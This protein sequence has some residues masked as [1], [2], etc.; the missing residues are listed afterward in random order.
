MA[1]KQFKGFT[2]VELLVVI[3]IIAI[4]AAVIVATTSSATVQARDAQRVSTI[5]EVQSALELYYNT[6]S[7]Y[8]CT[9]SNAAQNWNTEITK[10]VNAGYISAV[11]T[12][13]VGGGYTYFTSTCTGSKTQG[14]VLRADLEQST[15][16]AGTSDY[17]YGYGYGDTATMTTSYKNGC[18]GTSSNEP[19]AFCVISSNQ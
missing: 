12:P 16:T 11:P 4:L 14:Y 2:L 6:N 18:G 3:V 15:S 19:K 13:P 7:G 9:T 8:P 17:G 5:K 1:K 10:L